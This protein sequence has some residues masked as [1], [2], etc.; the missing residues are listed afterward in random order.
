MAQWTNIDPNTLLPGDPWTSAKAQ[1]SFENVE[2][3]AEGAAGAPRLYLRVLEQPEVGDEI[4]AS[5]D[6]IVAVST[7]NFIEVM[8]FGFI[9]T[10]NVRISAEVR[11]ASGAQTDTI[12]RIVRRR[13]RAD[14]IL[15][16]YV[17]TGSTWVPVSTD[18]A[19]LPGDVITFEARRQSD[20]IASQTR[21][22]RLKT[23]GQ[24]LWPAPVYMGDFVFTP[25]AAT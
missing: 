7:N 13:G 16:E 24:D 20:T 11:Q 1:A 10:G 15:A 18:F 12:H 22:L 25:R 14:T 4:Q 5:V 17:T 6:D 3:V 8:T 23:A 21:L 2:A 19:V 9:Q